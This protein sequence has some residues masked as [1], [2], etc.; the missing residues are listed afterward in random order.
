[1]I[2]YAILS[3]TNL[4]VSKQKLSYPILILGFK[5]YFVHWK[6]YVLTCIQKQLRTYV[7]ILYYYVGTSPKVWNNLTTGKHTVTVKASCVIGGTT[8]SSTRLKIEFQVR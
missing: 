2:A 4:Y 8:F 3:L 5:S 1:M 7:Y 6:T